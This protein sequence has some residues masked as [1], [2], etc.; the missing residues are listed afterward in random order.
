MLSRRDFL[1]LSALSL[2]SLGS[3]TFGPWPPGEISRRG[4]LGRV[5]RSYVDVYG[6][7][8]LDSSSLGIT[9]SG[10]SP[11]P[12]IVVSLL[13]LAGVFA[14]ISGLMHRQNGLIQARLEKT[15]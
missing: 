2:A 14:L 13:T 15:A 7:P 3:M 10:F 4:M 8:D 1:K 5:A 6:Q 9:Q 12:G 11:W